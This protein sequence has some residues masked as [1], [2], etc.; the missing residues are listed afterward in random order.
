MT[1]R[2]RAAIFAVF[3]ALWFSGC[4]WL[5]L[6]QFF[7]RGGQFGA[8]PH[9]WEP[10]VLLLHGVIAIL[11]MYLLGWITARHI[12]HFWSRRLRQ[13]SGGVLAAFLA[14][15]V[16][17]GFALFFLSDDQWQYVAASIHD[18]LG[19]GVTVF[20]VQHWFFARPS[21]TETGPQA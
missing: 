7:A 1:A 10:S 14:L 19:V 3:G 13:L 12:L 6:H 16:L 9:P 5:C 18:A 2:Q 21:D 4:L 17:S 8:T 11:S 15:L 20:G